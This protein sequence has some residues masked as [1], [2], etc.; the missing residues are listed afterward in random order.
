MADKL[1][2]TLPNFK[3][4]TQAANPPKGRAAT[5]ASA[6]RP[7]APLN[8]VPERPPMTHETKAP[9]CSAFIRLMVI[10]GGPPTKGDQVGISWQS[11]WFRSSSTKEAGRDG[12][13]KTVLLA[14]PVAAA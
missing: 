12:G 11:S 1:G 4:N 13:K 8:L 14:G 5:S 2:F 3:L 10:V 9:H 7:L 6:R